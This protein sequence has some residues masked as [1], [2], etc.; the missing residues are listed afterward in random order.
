MLQWLLHITILVK[1]IWHFI[2]K[3]N[4]ES[5]IAVFLWYLWKSW[6]DVK[7]KSE[8]TIVRALFLSL[9][10]SK[11]LNLGASMK[12]GHAITL[13]YFSR[14]KIKI[15]NIEVCVKN[16]NGAFVQV[17][18]VNQETCCY[19]FVSVVIGC[20][21]SVTKNPFWRTSWP[22]FFKFGM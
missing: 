4:N 8:Q 12:R 13:N 3:I 21:S 16:F 2:I 5:V 22:I 18:R 10:L 14:S 7:V 15:K 6:V 1:V 9:S 17:T 11:F 19:G 20:A